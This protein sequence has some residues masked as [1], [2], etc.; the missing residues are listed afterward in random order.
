MTGAAT[1]N[2]LTSPLI[3][4][5]EIDAYDPI[6]E[7]VQALY[8]SDHSFSTGAADVPSHR[9]VQGRLVR[10]ASFSR[11]AFS[12]GVTGR[13]ETGFGAIELNNKD[14]GLLSL[15]DLGFDG[16]RVTIR[17]FRRPDCVGPRTTPLLIAQVTAISANAD[18]IR[19]EL[20]SALGP[21]TAPVSAVRY[22]GTGGAEGTDLEGTLKPLCFGVVR[23]AAPLLVDPAQ[24]LYQLCDN[25]V[26][27]DT[28]YAG[29]VALTK[30]VKWPDLATLLANPPVPGSFDWISGSEGTLLR[31]ATKPEFD[32]TVDATEGG[33]TSARTIAQ[34]FQRVALRMGIPTDAIAAGDLARA[35]FERP[36]QGGLYIGPEGMR[37]DEALTRLARSIGGA[38]FVDRLGL[39]RLQVLDLPGTGA[40][41]H[42]D[43]ITLLDWAVAATG[44]TGRGVPVREVAVT[45]SRAETTQ[46]DS[47]LAGAATD[48]YRSFVATEARQAVSGDDDVVIA[49][50][51]AERL[52]VDTQLTD[53]AQAAELAAELMGLHGR[54]RRLV[55]FALPV[56]D[57]AGRLEIGSV[58]EVNLPVRRE[59]CRRYRIIG[60]QPQLEQGRI[61]FEA[62]G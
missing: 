29:G 47:A 62:W 35:D 6:R 26:T 32:L 5:A 41:A 53:S 61:R 42:L 16:R 49:H 19:L 17:Q 20:G 46:A 18:R 45:H 10:P 38:W 50:P 14:S 23:N 44:P 11:R 54:V 36:Y 57:Q 12:R 3:T 31:L 4:L 2:T 40:D 55:R 51:T 24:H 39:L 13:A 22:A 9:A 8:F 21:M 52:T 48:T 15:L 7:R 27:I 30:G 1:Q 43:D 58:V 56:T 25:A 33:T 60:V 59:L 37:Q 28:V 34:L